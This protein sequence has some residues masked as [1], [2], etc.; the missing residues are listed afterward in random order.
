MGREEVGREREDL[1]WLIISFF[2][3]KKQNFSWNSFEKYCFF[4]IFQ[5]I[6]V[7][8]DRAW[9]YKKKNRLKNIIN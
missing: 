3:P 5:K 7:G 8:P 4:E 9:K 2:S 1:K 6:D